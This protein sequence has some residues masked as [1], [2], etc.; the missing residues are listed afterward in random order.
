[1]ADQIRNV[2][3]LAAVQFVLSRTFVTN[4]PNIFMK[5]S[6]KLVA[7]VFSC[8]AFA[9]SASAGSL[10]IPNFHQVNERIYRGGQPGQEAWRGLA[11]MGVKTVIDLRRQD[12]HSTA[13][14][15]Q[16][17]AAAGMM[18]VNIP[19]KG[20]VAPTDEQISK[21]IAA[22]NSEERVFIHC[23]K[24]ADRTGAVIACYRIAHDGWQR[25]KALQEAKSFGM[26]S[27]QLGLKHYVMSYRP[28]AALPTP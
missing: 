10:T 1:M 23:K 16:A 13:A 28:A 26:G 22:L 17:V 4:T 8:S 5:R 21:A 3:E 6:T 20:F 9:Y 19:M 12:E 2:A 7:F 11:D 27:L 14:E 25:E 15:A 18:Y 24:G